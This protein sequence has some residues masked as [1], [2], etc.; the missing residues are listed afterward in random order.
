[1]MI[2][3]A[4]NLQEVPWEILVKDFRDDLGNK[5]FNDLGGYSTELFDFIRNHPHLFPKDYQDKLFLEEAKKAAFFHMFSAQDQ[6]Q[7]KNATDDSQRAAAFQAEFAS[8]MAEIDSRSI[9]APF[10]QADIDAALATYKADVET[11][12]H[13]GMKSGVIDGNLDPSVLAEL[14]VK[15]VI[16]S[17]EQ[18]M[19]NT[20]VVI[21]G[22]G[23]NEYFPG[24]IEYRCYGLLLGKFL[25]RQMDSQ[26]VEIGRVS[27]I[28]PFATTDMVRTFLMGFSPDVL[29]KV[30]EESEK[31]LRELAEQ[32]K[33]E[34]GVAD[35]PNL[36]QHI[37]DLLR[38]TH[39]T[40]THAAWDA[41][42]RPLTR[43]VG[44]LPVD[45]MAA[46][47][48]TLIMLQSLK[49]KVTQPTES[50][51]GPIDVAV[52]SKSDGFVWIKRKHYFDPSLNPR[53][54]DRQRGK[55]E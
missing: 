48:K 51:G 13:N 12:I 30:D 26:R 33:K 24:F 20:G 14:A 45:E 22:F 25:Y 40:W 46:L 7:F 47:A 21:A 36:E 35:I 38:Q 1:M 15:D 29:G 41:H 34:L 9:P 55:L 44:S 31:A 19:T 43:V 5:S 8:Q 4:A 16:K 27:Y 3:G 52:I 53:F 6:D 54:F 32:I 23:D 37:S 49:E 18:Y 2:F 39:D 10:Q 28:K 50:V 42:F 17:Y 11:N